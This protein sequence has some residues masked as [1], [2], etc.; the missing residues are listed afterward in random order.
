MSRPTAK[1]RTAAEAVMCAIQANPATDAVR[2][3]PRGEGPGTVISYEGL[4]ARAAHLAA[5]LQA[6]GAQ[7]ERVILASRDNIEMTVGLVACLY[8]GAVAVPVPVPNMN[9]SGPALL[10]LQAI[11]RDAQARVFL[12]DLPSVDSQ[13]N[14]RTLPDGLSELTW[15]NTDD[16]SADRADWQPPRYAP[17]S[18]ALL[19][20]TSGSTGQPK[21]VMLTQANLLSNAHQIERHWEQDQNELLVS[22]LPQYHDFGLIFMALQA[23]YLGAT[24][25]SMPPSAFV[26][27]PLRWLR[28]LT[29]YRGTN[30]G[31]PNFAFDLCVEQSTPAQR[32]GLDLRSVKALN[33]GAEPV[34]AETMRRFLAA[35]APF[36]LRPD[37][38][39]P[40]YGLAEATVFVTGWRGPAVKTLTLDQ[41]QLNEGRVVECDV[42]ATPLTEVVCC[43]PAGPEVELAIVSTQT[44]QPCAADEV[45]EIWVRGPNISRG[46]FNGAG[47]S[48]D[49]FGNVAGQGQYLRTGDLGFVQDGD[50]YVTGRLKDL[51]I[52]RGVN[53]YPQ[54][55]EF[56]VEQSHPA[57]RPGYCAAFTLEVDGEERL[58]VA[59]EIAADDPAQDTL[60]SAMDSILQAITSHHEVVPY[61]LVLLAR[62]AIPKTSSGKIQRQLCKQLLLTD[63]LPIL[64]DR[65]STAT[66]SPTPQQP[67]GGARS[68][69]YR[70]MEQYLLELLNLSP[71]ELES[72]NNLA[73]YGFDSIDGAA[74]AKKIKADWDIEVP[75]EILPLLTIRDLVDTLAN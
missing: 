40:G 73:A 45:G 14:V 62:G 54:D 30:S 67:E 32:E 70:A 26:Q 7:G 34:R 19:Q 10:R 28:C 16:A 3:L 46:Y 36:G 42:A 49:C 68:A 47:A 60:E 52:V 59:A 17:E 51:V 72:G 37:A 29:Q 21:G 8:S 43:G 50:L 15:L 12:T 39:R 75:M 38:L 63:Q 65:V 18:A 24:L 13:S 25:V 20:Y 74:L 33:C 35:F 57:I 2:F 4:H 23:L 41:R 1:D 66:I 53:H 27:D 71:E 64:G 11:A 6:R 55:I 48:Q 58:G 61:R 5:V 31:A 56:S 9:K 22:W 44:Q 69:K